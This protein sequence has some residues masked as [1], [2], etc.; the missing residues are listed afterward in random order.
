LRR[1]SEPIHFIVF[2]FCAQIHTT[3]RINLHRHN[4]GQRNPSDS[5]LR[6]RLK[7]NA[8]RFVAS[9]PTCRSNDGQTTILSRWHNYVSQLD[10]RKPRQVNINDVLPFAA[11]QHFSHVA[12]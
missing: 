9:R 5:T 12:W 6:N 11:R 1:C 2:G 8:K 4:A 3:P 10:D 7:C